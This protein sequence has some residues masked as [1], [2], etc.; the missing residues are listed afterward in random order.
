MDLTDEEQEIRREQLKRW[1]TNRGGHAKVVQDRG[2]TQSQASFLSQLVNGYSFGPRA[3]R[4][5]EHR[6]GMPPKW[7]EMPPGW[8]PE[9]HSPEGLPPQ[10][11][12]VA[13]EMSP[14]PYTDSPLIT[15]GE[16]MH[17]DLPQK[18]R[19]AAPDDSMAPR[20]RVGE[21]LEFD[22]SLTPRPGDGVLVRDDAGHLYF[23]AYREGRPGAWEAAAL[24]PAFTPLDS[25]RDGLQVLAVLTAVFQRWG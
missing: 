19:V 22:A 11:W 23:R 25:Q 12:L 1:L 21:L 2:L 16:N 14:P 3:A 7:L 15:W 8:T 9:Q 20:V 24:N 18:F 13:H 10:S 6:L 5:L 4:N 17:K